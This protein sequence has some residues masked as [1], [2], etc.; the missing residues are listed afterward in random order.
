MTELFSQISRVVP[1]LLGWCPLPKAHALASMVVALR[2]AVTIEIGVFG[3]RSF[4]PMALAHKHNG[5]GMAYGIDPW[6]RH[7][8][9]LGQTGKDLEWWG[10]TCNHE[11]VFEEFMRQVQV[12]GVQNVV[13]V[14]RM[15]SDDFTPIPK[16]DVCHVDGNHGPQVLKDVER[17]CP[18]VRLGG[19][20]ILDDL[21]WTGNNVLKAADRLITMG[22]IKLYDLGTGA[23]YQ[24]ISA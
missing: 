12:L 13:K 15:R 2:P 14:C 7:E 6:Q 5:F 4:L 24:K 18:H 20:C 22:F 21:H 16:I 1:T 3:G 11:A 23:C 17:F 9:M 19:L 10:T 8:S